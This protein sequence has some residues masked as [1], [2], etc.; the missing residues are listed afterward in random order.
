MAARLERLV[1]WALRI[2]WLAVGLS[3]AAALDHL[4]DSSGLDIL[5]IVLAA[6]WIV[7]AIATSFPAVRTLTIARVLVPAAVPVSATVWIGGAGANASALA[8]GVSLVATALVASADF[9]RTSV[10]ASAY[11]AEERHVLRPPTG[12]L[13]A[14]VVTWSLATATSTAAG[15]C[16]ATGRMVWAGVCGAVAAGI[17][18]WSAPRWHRL[19]RRWLVVVPAG[20]VVHDHLV[21]AETLMI[22]RPDIAGIRLAPPGATSSTTAADLT[23]PSTGH[24]I[25][26]TTHTPA[27]AIL[28]ATPDRPGGRAIHLTAALVSPTRPGRALTGATRRRVGTSPLSR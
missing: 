27:T 7:G 19:S 24:A 9:G 3:V 23:G 21:L 17:T 28:A 12:Y 22:N 8:V 16:L 1:P 20:L 15:V 26:I 4:D 11:G 5:R 25:E 2:A 13:A 10:Q 18:T 6:G 14:A